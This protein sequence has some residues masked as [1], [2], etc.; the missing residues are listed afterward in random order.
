MVQRYFLQKHTEAQIKVSIYYS[1]S[2]LKYKHLNGGGNKNM[3]S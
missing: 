1:S 3:F 2:L